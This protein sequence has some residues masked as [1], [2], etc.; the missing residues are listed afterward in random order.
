MSIVSSYLFT[1]AIRDKVAAASYFGSDPS[2]LS[3]KIAAGLPAS[4][5]KQ[6]AG[7]MGRDAAALK[8]YLEATNYAKWLK[9][10]KNYQDFVRSGYRKVSDQTKIPRIVNRMEQQMANRAFGGGMRFDVDNPVLKETIKE[11]VA[12]GYFW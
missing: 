8:H 9:A 12:P 6:L 2:Y 4:I 1:Q 11:S 7:T 10:S 5:M 3:D